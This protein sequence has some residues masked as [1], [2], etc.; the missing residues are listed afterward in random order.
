MGGDKTTGGF[1]MR[2]KTKTLKKKPEDVS[3]LPI[4]N[5]DGSSTNQA[6]GDN[7]E[8]D[9]NFMFCFFMYFCLSND[10]LK[11]CCLSNDGLKVAFLTK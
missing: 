6:P 8:G 9:F 10:G 4:W 2:C 11:S 1:D 3:E 5:Y 7:S